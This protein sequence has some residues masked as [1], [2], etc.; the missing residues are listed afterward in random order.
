MYSVCFPEG[1]VLF[2]TF[3]IQVGWQDTHN[4]L[5]TG[6]AKKVSRQSGGFFHPPPEKKID[7]SSVNLGSY[8]PEKCAVMYGNDDDDDDDGDNRQRTHSE[9]RTEKKTPKTGKCIYTYCNRMYENYRH[10]MCKRH[11]GWQRVI[12]LCGEWR[13]VCTSIARYKFSVQTNGISAMET[14]WS[15]R[16]FSSLE[17][18]T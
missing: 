5:C 10:L 18:Y 15:L 1:N 11:T 16:A 7:I 3:S 9:R 4:D 14:Y 2:D 12:R 8:Q 6:C 17:S 13:Y